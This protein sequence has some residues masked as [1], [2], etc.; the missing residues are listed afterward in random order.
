MGQTNPV[1]NNSKENREWWNGVELSGNGRI[2]DWGRLFAGITM[3]ASSQNLCEVDDP[4][5]LRYCERSAKWLPQ[6]KLGGSLTLPWGVYASGTF[7][8]F[9]GAALPVTYVVNR[10][11]VPTL[12][13]TSITVNLDDP[14]RPERYADRQ[15]QLDVRFAK[16]IPLGGKARYLNAQF[17]V[18]NALN[19]APILSTITSFGPTV[20][21]PRT[22]MQGRLAQFGVQ[23]Y[24]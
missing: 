22:I 21:Q 14:S 11:V 16:R 19:V 7:S 4:N 18:F 6:Y 1:D 20:Y 15:N 12:T 5:Q 3:G 13:Q 23:L 24:F 17:D 10:T 9:P 8:S 2:G